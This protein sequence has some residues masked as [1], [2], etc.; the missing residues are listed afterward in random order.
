MGELVGRCGRARSP[1]TVAYCP[2]QPIEL[3]GDVVGKP[4]RSALGGDRSL[5]RLTDPPGGVG[6]EPR[7]L[8][9]VELANGPNQ[10]DVALLDE[11]GE[12]ETSTL[13]LLGDGYDEQQVGPDHLVPDRRH[14]SLSCLNLSPR[15]RHLRER[16]ARLLLDPFE[17]RS[18]RG[19]VAD[20]YAGGRDERPEP[21]AHAL[22]VLAGQ[23]GPG[24]HEGHLLAERLKFLAK[25]CRPFLRGWL[26]RAQ[27]APTLLAQRLEPGDLAENAAQF[28]VCLAVG[29]LA[30]GP[31]ADDDLPRGQLP[32]VQLAAYANEL[33]SRHRRLEEDT[34][35]V[36]FGLFDPA[37]ELDLRLGAGDQQATGASEVRGQ[38]IGV[39]G[40][41]A[42]DLLQHGARG[43]L[44]RQV[45]AF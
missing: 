18:G 15:P 35:Q 22:H 17:V 25:L 14:P 33:S 37:R 40:R 31:G 39:E 24:E 43:D 28:V 3:L 10:A 41:L 29:V 19:A 7:P 45:A 2:A 8:A 5:Q 27:L 16:K 21:A 26:V 30:L 4:D 36:A 11:V 13:V 23:T 32:F 34:N 38:Q 9:A 1:E 6:R 42:R 20:E 44:A 12:V